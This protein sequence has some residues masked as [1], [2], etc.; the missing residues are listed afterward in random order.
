MA[1]GTGIEWTDATW[2]IVQ[3]CDYESPGCAHCYVPRTLWRLMHNPNPV[4]SG[5]IA[6]L[7]RKHDNGMPIF[8]GRLALR[9]DRLDWP[10]HWKKPRRIF[11][12]SHGDLFHKDV[13]DSFI[14][15]VFAI[16]A[17]CPRHTFQV[18]TKRA[19]RMCQYTISAR[20][21]VAAQTSQ[22]NDDHPLDSL[23]SC[24]ATEMPWPLPNVWLGVS[25]ED[26][27]R[28]DERIPELLN[29][30]AAIRFL[31][32]EPLLGLI[33]LN[34][35]TRYVRSGALIDDALTGFR[36]NGYGGSYGHKVDW[37][38]AGN[39][40]GPRRRPGDLAW[41]RSLRD[42]CAASGTKFF[43]KQDDKVKPLPPDL[44]LREMPA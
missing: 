16:M 1:D 17:L 32:C 30:P 44:M 36:S 5:P 12:P 34:M 29:T 10:L 42:Q 19:K 21:R 23:G 26:Q 18:L 25:V 27:P 35:L 41:M 31:S 2:P 43:G 28:A 22:P 4:I 7:V 6:G 37:V 13:P 39:E 15:R 14:D 40:S 3:G 38:I 11:V 33:R 24:G 8:T 9:E 20:D